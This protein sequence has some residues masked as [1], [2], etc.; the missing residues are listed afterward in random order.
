MAEY[1]EIKKDITD[2]NNNLRKQVTHV[3][4]KQQELQTYINTIDNAI[5]QLEQMIHT[6][7]NSAKPNYDK[8]R[9]LRGAI[10]KNVE[11]ITNLYNSYKEFENVKFRYYKEIDDNSYRM[12][13][14]IELELKK[15]DENA[16]R[17]GQEFYNVMRNLSNIKQDDTL[18]KQTEQVLSKEEYEL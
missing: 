14:L 2:N 11:L 10:T 7:Q 5:T 17:L 16:N 6:E 8:I 15:V 4:L 18:L 1:G 9:S 12:H 13:R 3:E